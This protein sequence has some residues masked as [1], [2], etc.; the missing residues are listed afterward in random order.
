MDG[1]ELA[2]INVITESDADELLDSLYRDPKAIKEVTIGYAKARQNQIARLHERARTDPA[3][4]A[5]LAAD[6]VGVLS[7]EG[8]LS[9]LDT[10]TVRHSLAEGTLFGVR[11]RC[12]VRA[13]EPVLKTDRR[14]LTLRLKDS[15]GQLVESEP[16]L[17]LSVELSYTGSIEYLP[18]P[19]EGS[20][21]LAVSLDTP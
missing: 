3:F 7:S 9:P 13:G 8:V 2:E 18:V 20:E 10:V 21:R 14:W 5:A 6:P 17:A 15:A 12:R 11:T 16:F 4:G 1:T 19:R